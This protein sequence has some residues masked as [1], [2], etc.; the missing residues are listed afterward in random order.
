[1]PEFRPFS[2]GDAVSRGQQIAGNQMRLSAMP[3]QL[4]SQQTQN[5]QQETINEQTINANNL[6]Q[7][8]ERISAVYDQNSYEQFLNEAEQKNVFPPGSLP[9]EYNE[10]ARNILSQIRGRVEAELDKLTFTEAGP[11]GTPQTTEYLTRGGQVVKQGKPYADSS[12]GRDSRTA[13]QKNVP[14]LAKA[15]GIDEKSAA[16]MLTQSKDKSPKRFWGDAYGRALSA[17]F[18]DTKAATEAANMATEFLYGKD[19]KTKGD[20]S[21]P[22]GIRSLLMQ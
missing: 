3:G 17:N 13:L 8:K 11:D 12:A 20:Q 4:Q 18:G 16:E 21:D 5:R 6:Q 14:F 1:M 10:D 9:R 19:W 22:D 15:M 2:L 7:A